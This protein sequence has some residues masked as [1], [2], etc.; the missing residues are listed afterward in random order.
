MSP[1]YRPN[2]MRWLGAFDPSKLQ[3]EQTINTKVAEALDRAIADEPDSIGTCQSCGKPTK[4]GD[5]RPWACSTRCY[6]DLVGIYG[7]DW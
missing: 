7:P 6:A 5:P 4:E 3:P 2:F 1:S